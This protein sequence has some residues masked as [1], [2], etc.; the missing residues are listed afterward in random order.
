MRRVYTMYVLRRAMSNRALKIYIALASLGGTLSLVSVTNVVKNM[1]DLFD[2]NA[3][4]DF[5]LSAV[6]NTEFLVQACL[7]AA[8][9]ALVALMAE[10]IPGA[11]FA[12]SRA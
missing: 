7:A 8:L 1:P 2:M 10:F 4:Y 6:G 11:R 12:A 9:V 5:A 3:W